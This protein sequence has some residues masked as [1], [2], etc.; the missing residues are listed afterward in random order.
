MVGV[1]DAE[2]L[3]EE[4]LEEEDH[5]VEDAKGQ[6]DREEAHVEV[7]EDQGE[8]RTGEAHGEGGHVEVHEGEEFHDKECHGES[9]AEEVP[10]EETLGEEYSEGEYHGEVALDVLV[11]GLVSP[12]EEVPDAASVLGRAG[13]DAEVPGEALD[14]D[15]GEEG[16]G[17]R[18]RGVL[19]VHSEVQVGVEDHAWVVH[20]EEDRGRGLGRGGAGR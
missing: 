13:L 15:L 4:S 5:G 6:E 11:L 9:R 8:A 16:L 7:H 3:D 18:D 17:G 1:P 12:G 10:G 14:E 19:E 2:A 20:D